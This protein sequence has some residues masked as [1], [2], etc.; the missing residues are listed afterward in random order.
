MGWAETQRRGTL[1]A[2]ALLECFG[3]AGCWGGCWAPHGG[4]R[5][6][7]ALPHFGAAACATDEE[8]GF[9]FASAR[10]VY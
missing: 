4:L 10:G 8:P 6:E 2:E 3:P 5:E 7:E 9:H 1:G